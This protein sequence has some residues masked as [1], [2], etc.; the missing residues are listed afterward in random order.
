MEEHEKLLQSPYKYI[1]EEWAEASLPKVGKKTFDIVCLMPCGMIL[2]EIPIGSKTI[3]PRI[4]VFECS[5]SGTGKSSKADKFEKIAYFPLKRRDIS[6]REL[7]QKTIEMEMMTL[8][9]EDFTQFI[10]GADGYEKVKVLEGLIGEEANIGMSNMRVEI[11]GQAHACSLIMGTP[12]DLERYAKN[13]EGGLLSRCVLNIIY[14]SPE[15]HNFIG[16]YINSYAGDKEYAEKMQLKENE[17][18]K[19]YKNLKRIQAGED[20]NI[21]AVVSYKIDKKFKDDVYLKWSKLSEKL[22]QDLGEKSYIRDLNYYYRF[23][24]CSAFLNIL[25]R[26]IEEVEIGRDSETGKIIKGSILH[27]NE[28]DHKLAI[29]LMIQNMK[30]KWALA[31]AMWYKRNIHTFE[32]FKKI[33]ENEKSSEIKNILM[34]ISP[35]AK[36]VRDSVI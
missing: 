3:S 7:Q 13:I 29:K 30:S 26:K 22:I 21:S 33:L 19:F 20:E 36:L 10:G 15:E 32:M 28:E 17:V 35:H 24:V 25:N 8:I 27:P 16:H 11:L 34:Y 2:P 1:T 9:I 23:L 31:K 4:N 6:G 5:A 12:L 14:L 18:I